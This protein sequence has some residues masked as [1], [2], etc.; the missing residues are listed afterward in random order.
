MEVIDINNQ[1]N[2]FLLNL[3]NNK[4][5]HKLPESDELLKINIYLSLLSLNNHN[6]HKE[7]FIKD[8][9]II[10]NFLRKVNNLKVKIQL[11]RK[12]P[13]ISKVI[14]EIDTMYDEY[15]K[16]IN[17]Y[18]KENDDIKNIISTKDPKKITNLI[19]KLTK[20]KFYK[21]NNKENSEEQRAFVEENIF[22]SEYYIENSTLYVKTDNEERMIPLEEFYEIFDYLL[23]IDNYNQVFLNNKEN[24]EHIIII[25]ELIK[26]ITENILTKEISKRQLV[27]IILTHVLSKNIINLNKIDT[28]NFKIDNIKIT[29]LYSFANNNQ[30]LETKS[31]KWNKIVIPNQYLYDKIKDLIQRGMYYYQ[32]DNFTLENIENKTSDFKISIKLTEM[33][34]LLNEI[35]L[36]YLESY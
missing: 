29:D 30:S 12:E 2:K 36:D 28:S 24:R 32:E 4:D 6:Y 16:I 15:N 5:D 18:N 14:E 1:Y 8:Q 3:L 10:D 13:E 17:K 20:V 26:L 9:E 31:A 22:N 21:E 11:K 23:E 19:D 35:I 7:Y 33:T 27:P 34:K 25:S